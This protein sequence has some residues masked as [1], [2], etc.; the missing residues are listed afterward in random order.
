MATVTGASLVAGIESSTGVTLNAVLKA[1]LTAK[2]QQL[3]DT[4]TYSP[5]SAAIALQGFSS[6][7]KTVVD[8]NGGTA[9][10]VNNVTAVKTAVEN[11]TTIPTF[12]STT[13]TNPTAFPLTTGADTPALSANNDTITGVVSALSSENTLNALDK[14]DGLAGVDTIKLNVSADFAGF[15]AGSGY[16]KNVEVVELTN[17]GSIGRSFAAK[18]VTDVTDYVIKG[19]LAGVNLTDLATIPTSVAISGQKSGSSSI[20][21][22]TDV[23]KGTA[24]AM[25]L[26]LDGVGTAQVKNAA[27]VETT[28]EAALGVTVNGIETM[29]VNSTNN[30][31]AALADSGTSGTSALNITGAGN[32][33]LTA[34][35]S[36]VKTVDAGAATGSLDIN[37]GSGS[38]IT[39]LTGGSANDTFRA[40]TGN[41]TLNAKIVGGAGQDVLATSATGTVQYDM[42]GV[43][44]V[45]LSNTGALIFSA[46]KTTGLEKIVVTNGTG[47]NTASFV[48][49][50]SSAL[51]VDLQQTNSNADLTVDTAGAVTANVQVTSAATKAAP[52]TSSGDIIASNA[53]SLTLNV[54]QYGVF[55]GTANAANATE[56]TAK[57]DGQLSGAT[58]SAAKATG[59]TI[60]D[61]DADT[62][63]TVTL[64]TAALKTLSINA[65]GD[66][67]ATGSSGVQKVENLTVVAG[68]AFDLT[69]DLSAV[70]KVTLSGAGTS[71]KVDLDALGATGLGYGITLDATGLKGGLTVGQVDTGAGNAIALNVSGVTG[72]VSIGSGS[73]VKVAQSNSA[74]T[75]SIT[76]NAKNV[77]GAVTLG[78]LQAK[79][80]SVDVSAVAG[81][82]NVTSLTG[83]TITFNAASALGA[84]TMSTVAV[85]TALTYTGAE[86]GANA[87]TIDIQGTDVNLFLKGGL[88]DDN[89][90]VTSFAATAA[91]QKVTFTGDL[92]LQTASGT[93]KVVIDLSGQTSAGA[94]ELNLSGLKGVEKV[95]VNNVQAT[96][97]GANFTY[98]GVDGSDIID[99]SALAIAHTTGQV[100]INLFAADG[101]ADQIK[102]GS[103]VAA[104]TVH[105]AFEITGFEA[106]NTGS[107]VISFKNGLLTY[108]TNATTA[109]AATNA[110][111]VVANEI[112][113]GSFNATEVAVTTADKVIYEISGSGDV[114]AGKGTIAADIWS[115][116]AGNSTATF[117]GAADTA[118]SKL[119][120]VD[121]GTDSYLWVYKSADA[122]ASSD[123]IQLIGIVKGVT[124]FAN[125]DFNIIA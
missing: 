11:G 56:V 36:G 20:A 1:S 59:L 103:A 97:A 64:T 61:T 50:G 95:N 42:S 82:V 46:T 70:N 34:I 92:G 94:I 96:Q 125:G 15:T 25:T 49:L 45:Q 7:I 100:K 91:A 8:A 60:T 110:T 76:V 88:Q 26:K 14:I 16:L 71:S 28:A 105:K 18:G 107:D 17:A 115:A 54:A 72:A 12:G 117:S 27:G 53:S 62:A 113:K 58:I 63:E 112:S 23:T 3:I 30:V 39:S 22:A 99:L 55:A 74:D 73:T 2:L 48:G 108:M 79:T 116:I 32:T 90:T 52:Q 9:A 87:A 109:G 44:T 6:Q 111:T 98:T 66:F 31:V 68:K 104:G 51:T 57:V 86:L 124:D 118:V 29:T 114:A 89:F 93:D 38:G 122:T 106:G 41:L 13:P 10:F 83:D 35:Q 85:K 121:D 123:D 69:G 80:V 120:V 5:L 40:G 77:G 43:E 81:A 75:G 67:T 24:D 101:D 78:S 84:V 65:A 119:F 37:L 33:K 47:V 19:D 21:F 102:F 4:N